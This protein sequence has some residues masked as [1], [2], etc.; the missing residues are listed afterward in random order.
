MGKWAAPLRIARRT[1]RR[2][3]GRT[4]LVA[5]L[6]GL[7]VLAATWLGIVLK[8]ASPSGETLAANTIGR[9][10]GRLDVTQYGKLQIPP[11][12]EMLYGEPPPAEGHDKA[13]R[14]PSTFDP[15]PLLPAG[16][17]LARLF[18]DSGMVEVRIPDSKTTVTLL[19]GDG[20][21]PLT[22]GTVK[23]DKGRLPAKADEVA[24]SPSLAEKLGQTTTVES[25]SGKR[26]A[27][28]GIA[29]MLTTQS[30]PAIFATPDST[31]NDVDPTR[32]VQYLVD[33]P[34]SADAGQL[35][36]DLVN[37]GLFL[38]P[39]ATIVDPPPD[40]YGTSADDIGPYAAMALVIGFGILEIVLLAG[41]AFAVG[42]RRQTRELGLVMAAGGT[43]GDVRRIVAMQGLFAGLVG[44]AGGLVIAGIAVFS[45]KPLW[46]RMTDTIFTA[47]QIPW[48]T[49]VGI[50][51]LGLGAGLAAAVVPAISAGRQAPMAA[52]AG[53]FTVTA[54][55]ARIR[56]AAVVL[57]AAG[58][59][60]VF[61]GSA[62]IA[63]ALQSARHTPLGQQ[64]TATPTGPIALVL[65]GITASII[66]LVW[67]LPSL[68]V[69]VAGLARS[70][71]LSGRIAMR[72]AARHR[73]RTGPATAA[74]MMAVAGTAAVAFAA[75]NSIA[76]DAAAYIAAAREGDAVVRFT[77]DETGGITYTPQLASQVAGLLPVRKQYEL[78]YVQL[79]NTKPNQYG[80]TPVLAVATPENGMGMTGMP[81]Q[82]ADPAF[83]E[84]FGEYGAKVAAAMRDGKVVVPDVKL[85]PG[86][87][88][89]MHNDDA[90]KYLKNLDAVSFGP[91]PRVQFF[92]DTALI[93]PQAARALGTIQ[94]SEVHF[95][96]TREPSKDELAAVSRTLGT[97][98]GIQVEKGYQSPA[99]LFLIGILLAATVVT[100][101]GVAIS[102]SLSAAEGRADLATLAA[103]G[104]PPRRRRSLAAAQAWVLGQLGCVLGV[105]VGA[106]Y[107]YTAHA[108]FGS[109]HFVVPWAEIGGIVVVV[110]LFAGLLA[111]LLTRSRLPMVSRI[112]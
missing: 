23:L 52:L 90:D 98:E 107:G 91:P 63:A 50:A 68:V 104:A 81:L 25:T 19:T 95:E 37:Q 40:P 75:S 27:V 17:K 53:R 38:L 24:I 64:A 110:P 34:D 3:I 83:I 65:L 32:T 47:W 16:T 46:E 85:A 76:A 54:K 42:A 48:A 43:P 6:I 57:L 96:L 111:W 28:V 82:A 39:R 55:A 56:I 89:A 66:A 61:A 101:L 14:T 77:G 13:V 67:M 36:T 108:A 29:R 70:L 9:A 84:R 22:T 97:D 74:I 99:R 10:D 1:A 78:G 80:Y 26:Y 33:L 12:Q 58:L 59:V 18:V 31:L 41:T 35:S 2:S 51:L 102:V 69:K 49:I 4:L 71:P 15:S 62:M 72:D 93:S 11:G 21:S 44:V 86:Q 100:L 5:A 103:I 79:A 73:H 109:P 20:S 92:R 106:L 7:P 30:T 8:S 87:K 94:V 105:G 45:A 112:D 88:V 60:C